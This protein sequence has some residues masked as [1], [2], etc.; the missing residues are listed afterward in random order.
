[1]WGASTVFAVA[2]WPIAIL[3]GIL[4]IILLGGKTTFTGVSGWVTG[5]VIFVVIGVWFASGLTRQIRKER[6]RRE[7]SGE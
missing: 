2:R 4:L 1:M 7:S 6:R 5:A 3:A